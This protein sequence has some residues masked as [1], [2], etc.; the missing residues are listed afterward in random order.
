MN[1][2]SDREVFALQQRTTAELIFQT[3]ESQNSFDVEISGGQVSDRQGKISLRS[4]F[5][6]N[7]AFDNVHRIVT[8]AK[9]TYILHGN[10]ADLI[11]DHETGAD[12][13]AKR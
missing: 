1:G 8:K 5:G 7:L 12:S 2:S 10:L 4:S 13:N 9:E 3:K 11:E 6:P